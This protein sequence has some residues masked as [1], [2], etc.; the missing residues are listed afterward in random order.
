MKKRV[1][2]KEPLNYN[3]ETKYEDY[4]QYE[5][6]KAIRISTHQLE[7]AKLFSS[8]YDY[9]QTL[10]KNISY[11][12]VGV[13]WGHSAQMFIDITDA[14]SADLVDFYNGATGIFQSNNYNPKNNLETHEEYIKKKFNYRNN[15]NIL[16]GDAR[17][18]LPTLDKKYDFIFLDMEGE[19]F[20]IRKFLLNCSKM[21]N[22]N[23][24]IGITSYTNHTFLYEEKI[25]VYQSVNEFLHLNQDWYVDAIVLDPIAFHDIYIKKSTK[26]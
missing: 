13:A 16:K 5:V 11:L 15:I 3:D 17:D 14:K 25:G 24:I 26:N 20:L 12:E 9:A 1:L 4:E 8:R 19:R 7:K 21:I 22:D 6:E 18:V 10:N 23:G 2:L